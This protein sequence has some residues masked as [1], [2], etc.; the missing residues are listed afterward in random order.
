MKER[1]FAC[2]ICRKTFSQKISLQYHN[3]YVHDGERKA[4]CPHCDYRAPD[5]AKLSVHLRTHS[6]IRP[7][8]CDT[9]GGSFKFRSTYRAHVARHTNS[10]PFVCEYCKKAFMMAS[11]LQE[12]SRIHGVVRP[13]ACQLCGMTFKQKKRLRVHN[14]AVHLQDKRYVCD[15]CGSSHINNWNLRGHM[16]THLHVDN[17]CS[18]VC[19]LCGSN[20][21]GKAGLGAHM[22][23]RHPETREPPRQSFQVLELGIEPEAIEHSSME[24]QAGDVELKMIEV[25]S[26]NTCGLLCDS[27]DQLTAHSAD[28]H[29]MYHVLST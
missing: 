29:G 10:G 9:C 1:R 6:E 26:C 11:E 19:E 21:R 14:R 8:V 5:K 7:F 13:F 25:Y 27:L 20:F 22:R 17:N 24:P 2:N 3:V 12:H 15:I 16:K 4:A 18:N 28:Q 23:M